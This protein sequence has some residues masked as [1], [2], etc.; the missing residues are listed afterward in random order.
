MSVFGYIRSSAV[1]PNHDRYAPD[2]GHGQI[3]GYGCPILVPV[4]R[5]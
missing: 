2:T 3:R 4:K 1:D 5:S